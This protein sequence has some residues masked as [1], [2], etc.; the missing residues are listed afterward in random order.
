MYEEIKFLHACNIVALNIKKKMNM[1][2]RR[3]GK[4]TF[5][6]PAWKLGLRTKLL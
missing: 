3:E 5:A 4:W 6:S 2:V 1:G